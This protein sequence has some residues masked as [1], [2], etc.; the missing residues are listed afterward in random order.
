MPPTAQSTTE[1]QVYIN[2]TKIEN[3]EKAISRIDKNI[4]KLANHYSNRVPWLF[5]LLISTLVGMV[6]MLATYIIMH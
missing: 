3:L 4:E 2:K 6:S 5:A 1:Q